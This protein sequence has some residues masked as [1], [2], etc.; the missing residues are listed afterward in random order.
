MDGIIPVSREIKG[1]FPRTLSVVSS[2]VSDWK[3]ANGEWSL[4]LAG[5]SFR[6]ADLS[7]AKLQKVNLKN[8]DLTNAKMEL[9]ELQGA[10]LTEAQLLGANMT[11]LVGVGAKFHKAKMQGVNLMDAKIDGADM[12]GSTLH[13]AN[14]YLSFAQG[15]DFSEADAAGAN[16]RDA[17]LQ[18]AKMSGAQFRGAAISDGS[19]VWRASHDDQTSFDLI[20]GQETINYTPSFEEIQ[21][22]PGKINDVPP[23]PFRAAMEKRIGALM[24]TRPAK[25]DSHEM[26]RLR[27]AFGVRTSESFQKLTNYLNDLM[28]HESV[29][30]IHGIVERITLPSSSAASFDT[31][32]LARRGLDPDCA[33]E[34]LLKVDERAKLQKFISVNRLAPFPGSAPLP[35]AAPQSGGPAPAPPDVPRPSTLP[36]PSG[37]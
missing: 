34:T 18:G 9:T 3:T 13:G 30:A 26:E 14:F 25:D 17:T 11:S 12:S 5:R 6:E 31:L 29:G 28:C 2:D 36:T 21:T 32:F 15:V 33:G 27:Q 1:K 20:E 7:Y 24:K 16:F 8:P 10:D 19:R 22:L 4:D 23:G 35:Q 37:G